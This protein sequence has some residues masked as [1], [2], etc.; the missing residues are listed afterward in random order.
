ML[1]ICCTGSVIKVDEF[2]SRLWEMFEMVYKEGKTQV[3]KCF[4]TAADNK[5]KILAK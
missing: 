5:Y 4:K 1:S 2:T 3:S